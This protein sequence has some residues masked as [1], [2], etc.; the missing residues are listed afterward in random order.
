[1]MIATYLHANV[2]VT[3]ATI[4]GKFRQALAAIHFHGVENS[5]GLEAG[6]FHGCTGNM[7]FLCVSSDTP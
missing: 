6:R 5:F 3:H 1:M 4:D 7:S 2:G